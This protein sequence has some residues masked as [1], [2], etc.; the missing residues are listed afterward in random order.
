MRDQILSKKALYVCCGEIAKSLIL[1]LTNPDAQVD[2][3]LFYKNYITI[4]KIQINKSCSF[5]NFFC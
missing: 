3:R 2:I 5:Y 4:V 1:I